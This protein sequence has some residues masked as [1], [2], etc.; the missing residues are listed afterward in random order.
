MST[1]LE[2]EASAAS[3]YRLLRR[4]SLCH[5][6]ALLLAREEEKSVARPTES[7]QKVDA[8]KKNVGCV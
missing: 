6:K 4:L 2:S 1:P 5:R 7:F 8:K 3:Y